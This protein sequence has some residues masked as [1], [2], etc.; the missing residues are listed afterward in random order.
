MRFLRP[1]EVVFYLDRKNK[2]THE[3]DDDR[4]IHAFLLLLSYFD[5]AAFCLATT[6]SP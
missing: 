1:C 3:S 5:G 2:R 6:P 4:L